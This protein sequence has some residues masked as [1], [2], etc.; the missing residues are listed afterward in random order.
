L[1]GGGDAG[2]APQATLAR[3]AGHKPSHIA[4]I[5]LDNQS[6]R[7]QLSACNARR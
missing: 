2:R 7:E 1:R 5:P 3:L 6:H 4:G